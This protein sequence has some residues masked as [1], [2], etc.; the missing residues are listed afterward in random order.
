MGLLLSLG[1]LRAR[2]NF[3]LL[4]HGECFVPMSA[5]HFYRS[6]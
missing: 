1:G 3:Q 2:K 4:Q 5:T 6:L